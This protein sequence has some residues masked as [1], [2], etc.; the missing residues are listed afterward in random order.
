MIEPVGLK[1]NNYF[2]KKSLN[3]NRQNQNKPKNFETAPGCHTKPLMSGA[4]TN[5][6]MLPAIIASGNVWF[7]KISEKSSEIKENSLQAQQTLLLY[8]E[9]KPV[10]YVNEYN[11]TTGNIIRTTY[12]ISEDSP[13]AAV[14]DYEP[15]TGK[16]AKTTFYQD[17]GETIMG[18]S[19]YDSDSGNEIR[20]ISYND[21]GKT[22]S[23]IIE[24]AP[25]TGKRIKT[26]FYRPDG[27]I[28][29]ER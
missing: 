19:E 28:A 24:Y 7:G 16:A 21:D 27:S 15:E 14:T 12:Y 5:R 1:Y 26:T 18:V 29:L 22:V 20:R 2:V 25:D 8:L 6:P 9:D 11:P 4:G 3:F 10:D 17:D 13:A 23:F